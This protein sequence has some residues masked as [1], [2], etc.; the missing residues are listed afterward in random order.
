MEQS[1]LIGSFKAV[2][3]DTDC[4]LITKYIAD[5]MLKRPKMKYLL[6]YYLSKKDSLLCKDEY[7]IVDRIIRDMIKPDIVKSC[8]SNEISFVKDGHYVIVNHFCY[9]GHYVLHKYVGKDRSKQIFPTYPYKTM[10]KI[11]IFE[12]LYKLS[13]EEKLDE[14]FKLAKIIKKHCEI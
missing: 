6:E 13:P 14:M 4:R 5:A 11:A 3:E 9:K 1:L 7:D 8:G 2:I 12:C 10:T